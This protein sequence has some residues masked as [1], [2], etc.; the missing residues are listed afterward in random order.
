MYNSQDSLK[1]IQF[2][3]L[4][5][6]LHS[7][8]GKNAR[9]YVYIYTLVSVRKTNSQPKPGNHNPF[10]LRVLIPQG[11]YE[12]QV[13]QRSYIQLT[14]NFIYY[15]TKENTNGRLPQIKLNKIKVLNGEKTR[16]SSFACVTQTDGNKKKLQVQVMC[17]RCVVCANEPP[18]GTIN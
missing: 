16:T 15:W 2:D 5:Q 13:T 17:A 14:F 12:I 10:F 3:S 1:N 8:V 7:V 11:N 4:A 9:S 18:E 6:E